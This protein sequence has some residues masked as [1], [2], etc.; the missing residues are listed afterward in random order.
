MEI[1]PAEQKVIGTCHD[2]RG[3][4]PATFTNPFVIVFDQLL[5]AHGVRTPSSVKGGEVV[6]RMTSAP[7]YKWGA[8]AEARPR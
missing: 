3:G 8:G 4:V 7:D 2:N 5:T 6:F 1:I